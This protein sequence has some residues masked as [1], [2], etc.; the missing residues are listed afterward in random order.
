MFLGLIKDWLLT[1]LRPR[2]Y[3]LGARSHGLPILLLLSL[4]SCNILMFNSMRVS[5]L[6]V[7]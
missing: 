5:S 2:V 3:N 4:L 1:V 7:K 6:L